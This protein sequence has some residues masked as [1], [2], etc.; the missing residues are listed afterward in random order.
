VVI[1]KSIGRNCD[2][3]HEV[4]LVVAEAIIVGGN[5]VAVGADESGGMKSIICKMDTYML[6]MKGSGD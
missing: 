2:R 6:V 4:P 3:S 5:V 1:S